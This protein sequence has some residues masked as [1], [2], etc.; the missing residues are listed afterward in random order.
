[1]KMKSSLLVATLTLFAL[2]CPSFAGTETVSVR[3]RLIGPGLPAGEVEFVQNGRKIRVP[4]APDARSIVQRYKGPAE[5][6]FSEVPPEGRRFKAKLP[7]TQGLLLLVLTAPS[8]GAAEVRVIKDDWESFP[9]GSTL[10][11]NT[12]RVTLSLGFGGVQI[13]LLPG[14]SRLFSEDAAKTVFVKIER[15]GPEG[16]ETVFSSNWASNHSQ[17][18]LVLLSTDSAEPPKVSVLRVSEAMLPDRK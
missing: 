6:T 3:F 7:S 10:F 8:D 4:V 12:G 9:A 18:A 13:E 16:P 11:V 1:M 17:R 2:A 14:E 5:L 15:Q